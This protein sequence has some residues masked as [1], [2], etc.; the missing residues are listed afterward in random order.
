MKQK[1]FQTTTIAR[2][3]AASSKSRIGQREAAKKDDLRSSPI[4]AKEDRS[5]SLRKEI[6]EL[7]E[8]ATSVADRAKRMARQAEDL[9]E[10]IKYLETQIIKKS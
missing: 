10:R 4:M 3:K 7:R 5:Q 1:F 2:A 9:A 8:E 6:E